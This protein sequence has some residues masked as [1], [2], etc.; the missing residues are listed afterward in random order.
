LPQ[1]NFRLFFVA[2]GNGSALPRV[3][4]MVLQSGGEPLPRCPSSRPYRL[5]FGQLHYA[6]LHAI[7]FSIMSY[8]LRASA[9][10][11]PRYCIP[12]RK[13]EIA[14]EICIFIGC[15]IVSANLTCVITERFGRIKTV[16][17]AAY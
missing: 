5:V 16:N 8:S 17:A 6:C 1:E 2:C 11:I 14:H 10:K 13:R 12:L 7:V 4:E 3:A 15:Q 9:A